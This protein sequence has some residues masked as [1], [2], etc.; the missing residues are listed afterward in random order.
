[1]ISKSIKPEKQEVAYAWLDYM[2]T[3]QVGAKWGEIVGYAP[4]ARNA[5]NYMNAG[6][7]KAT[8]MDNPVKWVH[9]AIV[10]PDPGPRRQAYVETWQEIRSALK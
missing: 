3:P 1:M 5:K 9:G 10:K 8:H 4:A 7:I 6:T 2:M